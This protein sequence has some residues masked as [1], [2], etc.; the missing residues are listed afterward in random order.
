[1]ICFCFVFFFKKAFTNH[2]ET[3]ILTEHNFS[4]CAKNLPSIKTCW[5]SSIP[6]SST[7]RLSS[8]SKVVIFWKKSNTWNGYFSRGGNSVKMYLSHFS[9]GKWVKNSFLSEQW[10]LLH[11]R[12]NFLYIFPLLTSHLLPLDSGHGKFWFSTPNPSDK[13]S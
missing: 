12:S 7:V 6:A 5:L 3:E 9:I 2:Q 13:W 10:N 4:N 8:S 1:M 11:L